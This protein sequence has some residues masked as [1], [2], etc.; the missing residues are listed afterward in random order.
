VAAAYPDCPASLALKE[1]AKRL[2][3]IKLEPAELPK[4]LDLA[5]KKVAAR[6]EAEQA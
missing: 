1:I 6:V 2:L 3:K 5:I 4:R